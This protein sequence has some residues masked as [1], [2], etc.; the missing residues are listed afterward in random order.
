MLFHEPAKSAVAAPKNVHE[1][2]LQPQATIGHER[3]IP[4]T[5]AASERG[6]RLDTLRGNQPS[7]HRSSSCNRSPRNSMPDTDGTQLGNDRSTPVPF[8]S[9]IDTVSV[10]ILKRRTGSALRLRA[11]GQAPEIP[12]PPH[13]IMAIAGASLFGVPPACHALGRV[14]AAVGLA[15][16]VITIVSGRHGLASLRLRR[17]RWRWYSAR[18]R[19]SSALG[20]ETMRRTKSLNSAADGGCSSAALCFMAVSL[21]PWYAARQTE[22]DNPMDQE[23]VRVSRRHRKGCVGVSETR[24]KTRP[25]PYSNVADR[26]EGEFHYRCSDPACYSVATVSADTLDY[27]EIVE[28]ALSTGSAMEEEQ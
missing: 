13:G 9:A 11:D 21:P 5:G 10:C 28:K 22:G 6:R 4:E 19:S 8:R 20:T 1:L 14:A 3:T 25:H 12:G 15:K 7:L 26:G 16:L 24:S 2:N 18:R 27:R 23:I 17:F